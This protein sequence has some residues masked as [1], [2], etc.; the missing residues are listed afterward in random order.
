MRKSILRAQTRAVMDR[1][2]VFHASA[3]KHQNEGIL[4]LAPSG[5]GKSTM[6]EIL[7]SMG[8]VVLGDDSSIVSKGTD[9]VWRIIPC[10]SWRWQTDAEI[11][12]VRLHCLVFLEKGAPDTVMRVAPGYSAYRILR[13]RLLM[14]YLDLRQEERPA[15]RGSV[16][17]ICREHPSYVL[18][19]SRDSLQAGFLDHLF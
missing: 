5:G 6:A 14:S 4:F 17:R 2:A 7:G 19:R 11:I 8:F 16:A 3:V 15:L 10:A 12:P 18:R 9:G 13:D 1:G